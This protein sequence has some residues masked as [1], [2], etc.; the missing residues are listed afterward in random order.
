MPCYL[1]IYCFCLHLKGVF[2]R[3]LYVSKRSSL[4]SAHVLALGFWAGPNEEEV[5]EEMEGGEAG[6]RVGGDD[7]RHFHFPV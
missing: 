4:L 6:G 3:T 1:V 5:G 7:R 2:L